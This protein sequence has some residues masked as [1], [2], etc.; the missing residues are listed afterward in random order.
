MPT[1]TIKPNN[2]AIDAYY[3]T[4]KS[5]EKQQVSHEG[6]VRRAFGELLK[7]TAKA[8]KWVLVEELSEKSKRNQ[9]SIR[10]DG[11][12]R[13][14]WRLPH[15]YWEAKDTDDDLDVEI[16]KKR[17]KDYPF[18]NIIFEDTQTAVLFQDSHEVMRTDVQ[19]RDQLARLLTYF[20][21]YESEPFTNFEQ[22]VDHFQQEIPHIAQNLKAKIDSAHTDNKPFQT[23]FADFIELCRTALNPNISPAAV[24]EMLIQHMLTERI[25]R[26]VFNVETFTRRNVIAAEVEKVIDSLTGRFFN[27]QEFLGALDRFYT[28][29][30]NAADR[31]ATFSDKQQFI[32]TVY[33]KFFQGYSVDI[34]DTHG[35]VY[36]PQEIVDFMCAA[37]EEVLAD[38]FGKKLGDD[39][40]YIIDPATGTGNFVVNLLRCAYISNPRHFERFYREQLFANEVMLMPYYIASLNIEHEYYD[41]TGQYE[42][43]EGICFVDTLDLA[44][45][46]QM[47]F[48]F[49]TEENT[50]RVERQKQAPITVIIGN[51]PYNVGQINE[52][53][54]NKN[55][56]YEVVDKR[57]SE[58]YAKD[59]KATLNTKLYD[60]YVKFFRWSTDRLQNRAGVV[61]FVTNN[62]FV[63]GIAFD[64]FRKNLLDD[65][66]TVYHLD[67]GGNVRRNQ[68]GHSISNV[69]DIRVGVGITIAIRSAKDEKRKVFYHRIPDD[70][71]KEEK[72][73]YLAENVDLDGKQNSLNTVAWEELKPNQVN[74]WLVSEYFDEYNHLIPLGTKEAKSQRG[75]NSETIFKIYSHGVSTN[76]DTTVYDFISDILLNR[77]VEFA[78]AYNTEVDRYKRQGSP[79]DVDTFLTYNRVKWSR[80][81]KR[82]LRNGDY[83]LSDKNN[84][85]A[86]LYRPFTYR[87]LY[88]ADIAVDESGRFQD[89]FPNSKSELEN[90]VLVIP[91][92]GNR[93]EYGS[94][95]I[96]HITS[97]DIAF[98]KAQCFPFYVY[99]EDGG[100]RRENI[101]DWALAQFRAQYF[102]TPDS[103]PQRIGEG[104]GEGT[105][106]S[107]AVNTGWAHTYRVDS[108]LYRK[109]K[110]LAREMRT[111]PTAAENHLWQRLRR[112][113]IHG[114]KF[115]RQHV[116]DRFI[117]DF[118]CADARLVVEVDGPTHEYTEAEDALR[119]EFLESLG[120]HVLRFTNGEVLQSTDAVVERIG[121]VLLN[122][123]NALLNA[124]AKRPGGIGRAGEESES[125]AITKWDIFYYV[126]GLLHHPEY[127]ERYADNLKRELPRI[128]FAPDFWAFSDAGRKLAD[129]HLNYEDVEPYELEWETAGRIDYRVEKMRLKDPLPGPP[130]SIRAGEKPAY[131]V[132]ETLVYNDTLTLKGIPPEVFDYRLGNRSA[133]EWVIDQYRVKTDKRSGIVSDPNGYSDDERYIVNLVEK[134]IRVSLETVKIVDELARLPFHM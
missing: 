33:E 130:Q 90:Q 93:K 70:W 113:Q 38:E 1:V 124:T 122:S 18:T 112:K 94:L 19:D 20:Y 75:L 104:L 34:A 53:D 64:G 28:A 132:Y 2:P 119:T 111:E 41:L 118:F 128:P 134:V 8:R 73:A 11:T 80:N 71:R 91:G 125:R 30:E 37:V 54:N 5:L 55:R 40:V 82:H 39:D 47:R 36:T 114:Y 110:P 97:L 79:Q 65:F 24:D 76:R 23:A 126:Y 129:L 43:F 67:L 27:R 9:R 120:L 99:D 88:F 105:F 58:T 57:V 49:M 32:N 133:L 6:G 50:A 109:I 100:N 98:E 101:T 74:T 96:R 3:A 66:T 59:S 123:P 45:G 26:K 13:D 46:T 121:E 87:Y 83:L 106:P 22:A 107:Q 60:A 77:I 92:P 42:S 81:L 48:S 115:R 16:G 89:I 14:Q 95:V 52:N 103:P 108:D 117:I 61:C 84:L 15:G 7:D 12:L 44:E 69:F 85:R 131:R 86:C 31:L 78:E 10:L 21:N 62:G 29:I 72:L 17:Q 51:P 63:E 35:I 116:I 68:P 102:P 4:L 25:I 127:R 56:K